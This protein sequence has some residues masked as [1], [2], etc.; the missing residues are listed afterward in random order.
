[1][2]D[3]KDVPYRSTVPDV[4]HACGHDVHTTV[5]ARRRPVPG[6][7]GRRGRA[8]RPGPAGLPARRGGVPG[9]ALDVHRGGRDG[10][11]GADLRAA[12]R[13]PPGRRPARR[14]APAPITAACDRIEVR[15]SGPGGHTARPHLTADLVYALGKIV[16]E[17]PGGA[18]PAGRPAVRPQPGLGPGQRGH[19]GQRDP[20]RGRGRG[21][22]PLPGRRG[23]ARARPTCSRACVDSVASSYGV[24]AEVDYHAVR[25]ADGQ[26]RRPARP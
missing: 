23:L 15:V 26:R 24:D 1:M 18:V 11:G 3:D 17:V 2:T 14:C 19:G 7:A 6:R 4:C 22:R 16:T 5:A 13:P 10:V 21:H 9:G 20:R 8:A 25:A 12:L